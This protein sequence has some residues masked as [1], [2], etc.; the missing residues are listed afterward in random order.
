M[1]TTNEVFGK[2]LCIEGIAKENVFEILKEIMPSSSSLSN[3]FLD[4]HP[5]GFCA[6]TPF[7]TSSLTTNVFDELLWSTDGDGI[8]VH[9]IELNKSIITISID[10]LLV[11]FI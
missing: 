4:L 7:T 8:Y 11:E 1:S 9:Y 6:T 10:K 3:E 2:K 5:Y